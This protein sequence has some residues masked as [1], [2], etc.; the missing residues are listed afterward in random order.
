M[1]RKKVAIAEDD[2]TISDLISLHLRDLECDVKAFDKGDE[3]LKYMLG[4]D[5][6]LIILDINLPGKNGLE[7]CRILRQ[8]NIFTKI[9]VLTAKSEEDDKVI[10]FESGADDYLTK[11][12]GIREFIARVK[13]MLRRSEIENPARP[14][15]E[16]EIKY[17]KLTID[18][19]KRKVSISEKN[20]EL[21]PKEFD[22]LLLL[23]QH[24]GINF[25]RKTL[26][27]K[28]WG[29]NYAGY[30]HTVNSHINRL[31][32]KI[33]VDPDNPEYVLTTW[34]VGYKFND[35]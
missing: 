25:D 7:I 30:E 11:P 33:E 13:A 22:L 1:P 16:G 21:T 24:P 32:N 31:R 29:Y 18:K 17:R 12:F 10:G 4:N 28:V 26:L 19:Q 20:I 35:E 9:L 14:T 6:D 15:A 2:R 34:G 8:N 5:L 23:A 27:D 3:A